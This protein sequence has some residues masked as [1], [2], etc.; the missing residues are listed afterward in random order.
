MSDKTK[1]IVVSR[2][3]HPIT[4]SYNSQ[5]LVIPPKAHGKNAPRI[6][7]YSLLGKLPQGVSFVKKN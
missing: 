6:A 4:V 1:G 2:L 3:N 5:S 7:D